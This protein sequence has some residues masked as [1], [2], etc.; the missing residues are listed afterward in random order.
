[1]SLGHAICYWVPVDQYS[2]SYVDT[3][4]S[5]LH[6][7][8]DYCCNC[9]FKLGKQGHVGFCPVKEEWKWKAVALVSSWLHVLQLRLQGTNDQYSLNKLPISWCI[10]DYTICVRGC[11]CLR[12]H[13]NF[14]VVILSSLHGLMVAESGNRAHRRKLVSSGHKT[15]CHIPP[16]SR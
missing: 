12:G 6:V 2:Y 9:C 10:V 16:S 14:N 3:I 8:Q 1:M 7:P 11:K 13:L 15:R 4:L 5:I